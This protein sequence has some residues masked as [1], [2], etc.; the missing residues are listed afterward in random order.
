MSFCGRGRSRGAVGPLTVIVALV[1][2]ASRQG[3][4]LENEPRGFG[5]VLLGMSVADVQKVAPKMQPFG[6][7]TPESAALMAVYTLEDQTVFGLKHCK[8]DMRFD[9]NLLYEIEFNCGSDINVPAAL[10]KHLGGPTQADAHDAFWQGDKTMV[11][12]NTK[13]RQFAFF[14][15]KLHFGFQ[16]RLAQYIRANQPG[17][18]NAPTPAPT[19]E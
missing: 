8:V 18:A 4:S 1:L 9:P 3:F 10:Q 11:S 14:D 16:Q 19:P 2:L 12:L 6:N 5:K 15:N 7:P 17:G 13:S